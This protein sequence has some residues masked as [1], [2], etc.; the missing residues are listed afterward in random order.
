MGT[1][2]R[3]AASLLDQRL[4]VR[5]GIITPAEYVRRCDAA[6]AQGVTLPNPVV[7]ARDAWRTREAVR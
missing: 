2:T 1:Q 3:I 4:D 5:L 6:E 7:V